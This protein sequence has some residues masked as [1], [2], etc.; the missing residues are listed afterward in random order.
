MEL[1][2]Q[3]VLRQAGIETLCS[4]DSQ[5]KILGICP[6]FWISFTFYIGPCGVLNENG[7]DQSI[8]SGPIGRCG[9]VKV[10]VALL[11]WVWLCW[12]G[13]GLVGGSVSLGVHFEVSEAQ[14]RP[15]GLPFLLPAHLDIDLSAT[16]PAP[17][18]PT[19][20]HASCHDDNG[21]NCKPAPVKCFLL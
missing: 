1:K 19:C 9:F 18:L 12:S 11:E 4:K 2:N 14:A 21:L 15:R 10:G 7:P 13:C 6:R 16:C 5:K 8:K 20:C 17:Y 3:P